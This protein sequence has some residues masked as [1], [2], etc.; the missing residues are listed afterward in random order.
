MTIKLNHT[1]VFVRDKNE[2][3]EFLTDIFGLPPPCRSVRSWR[4]R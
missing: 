1:I 3:A 2:S 4:C